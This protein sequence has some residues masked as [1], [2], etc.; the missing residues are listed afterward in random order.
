[1]KAKEYL[2]YV[3]DLGQA[4]N[5]KLEFCEQLRELAAISSSSIAGDK[6]SGGNKQG[7]RLEEYAVKI[8]TIEHD[9]R[10][11]TYKLLDE[12]NQVISVIHKMK[13]PK[14]QALLIN[15]YINGYSWEKIAEKM[16]YSLDHVQGYAH[17]KALESF[18]D[19]WN[20]NSK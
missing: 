11:E 15:R 3:R 4:I 7:S 6:V 10:Y 9:M 8:M 1:M 20:V 14:E 5:A 18:S 2:K 12:K 16:S 19:I 17:R 13:E